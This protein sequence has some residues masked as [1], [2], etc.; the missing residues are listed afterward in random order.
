M[1]TRIGALIPVRLSSERLPGKALLPI[2]GRPAI[3]HLLD[4]VCASRYL[5]PEQV[6]V[7]TTEDASDDPLVPVV[8]AAGARVF[9]GHRDDIIERFY[10]AAEQFGFDAVIQADGD[11]PCTETIYM[12][13]CMD[14]LLANENLGIVIGE[15]LPFGLASKAIRVS[16]LRSVWERHVPGRND[17]GFIYYFTRAGIC[18]KDAVRPMSQDH[19]H[20]TARLTLDY[21]EDLEFFRALFDEL[22][23]DGEVFGIGDIV[24]L[25]KR[26]PELVQ[27]NA[28][29]NEGY[30]QRTRDLARLAYREGDTVRDVAV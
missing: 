29:L 21:P 2:A 15:G 28:N 11:D 25:L 23:R 19:E 22:Y 18:E 17:T 24:A 8:E 30:W 26:R 4:R 13:R 6:V 14:R 9:R 1:T 12:D 20:A 3:T 10:R 7:C 27:I 5:T 16:A